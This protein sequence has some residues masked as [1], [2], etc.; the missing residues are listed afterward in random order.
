M[1]LFQMNHAETHSEMKETTSITFRKPVVVALCAALAVGTV[2][3]A[4]FGIS[5]LLPVIVTGLLAEPGSMLIV[6]NPEAHL[7]PGGQS[8]IGQ[9]LAQIAFAGVKVVVE[10]HSEHVLNGMRVYSLKNKIAPERIC[11][12]YFSIND[13]IPGIERIPLNDRMDI[14][15]W[16]EGFFDQEEKDLA[17]LRMLRRK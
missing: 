16:P 2:G 14:L 6:E 17:E 13:R 1:H 4:G 15:K 3:T 10:T 11:I 5:Y 9:F 8:R 12:N 7:H